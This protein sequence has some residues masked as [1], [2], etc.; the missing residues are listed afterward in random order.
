MG[1]VHRAIAPC[2]QVVSLIGVPKE[3]L[4]SVPRY[5]YLKME[6]G[7]SSETF[8]NTYQTTPCHNPENHNLNSGC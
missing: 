6:N 5:T 3:R 2:G 7:S 8:V 1:T 4:A